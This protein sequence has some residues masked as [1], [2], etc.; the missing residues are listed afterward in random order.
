MTRA[1]IFKENIEDDLKPELVS[2]ITY[3]KDNWPIKV[4]QNFC[5]YKTYIYNFSTY[6]ISKY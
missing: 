4:V 5:P 6:L 3:V 2:T 1:T